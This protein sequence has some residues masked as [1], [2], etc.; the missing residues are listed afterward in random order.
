MT[1]DRHPT[2]G[3]RQWCRSYYEAMNRVRLA[4]PNAYLKGEPGPTRTW[5]IPDPLTSNGLLVAQ[6]SP[7]QGRAQ[8]LRLKA[9]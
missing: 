2:L 6:T 8:W 5:Y 7:A 4:Y 3:R 9:P 1:L